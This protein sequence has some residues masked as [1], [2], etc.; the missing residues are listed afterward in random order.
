MLGQVDLRPRVRGL[1]T[2]HGFITPSARVPDISG[3]ITAWDAQRSAVDNEEMRKVLADAPFLLAN[4]CR[5]C[6]SICQAGEIGAVIVDELHEGIGRLE[7]ILRSVLDIECLAPDPG[8]AF[9]VATVVEKF[10]AFF[11]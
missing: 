8:R 4:V 9:H 7:D 3:D 5:G 1:G 10:T 2:P 11:P 6:G